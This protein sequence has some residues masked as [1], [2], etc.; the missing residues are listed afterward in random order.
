M[1]RK[2]LEEQ[3]TAGVGVVIDNKHVQHI[4]DIE[5]INDRMIRIMIKGR[6]PTTLIGAYM[7]Q[8][9][10]TEED[11]EK[12]YDTLGKVIKQY[13]GRGPL[14]LLGDMNA[15]IQKAEGGMEKEH[16]GKYTF[17]PETAQRARDRS[18][19]VRENRDK[20]ITLCQTH[21]MRIMN[22]MFKKPK[23]KLATYREVGT[24]IWWPKERGHPYGYEQLDYILTTERWK[25]TVKDAEADPKA[26][27]DTRHHPVKARIRIKL[28]GIK[29]IQQS[30]KIYR[31][32]TEEEKEEWTKKT[33]E[34]I[35]KKSKRRI[36]V[37]MWSEMSI[38]D[39][40][41]NLRVMLKE[42]TLELKET[43]KKEKKVLFSQEAEEIL[44]R[45]GR[46]LE[47]GKRRNMKGSLKKLG[48]AKGK[49]K[50]MEYLRL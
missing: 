12:T 32:F 39:K 3:W 8:A 15:R 14:Y 4:T 18:L 22:T 13:K 50:E 34:I 49:T 33:E 10:R 36:G 31:E 1:G 27:I 38:W 41:D 44:E 2:L 20:L 40:T 26:N 25:N 17:E 7:P 42:A 37:Q 29:K 16:I 35:E 46:A 47:R 24:P 45:R 23:G 28:K 11:R 48:R 9:G 43:P 30:R 6:M 5:P 21:K 19:M